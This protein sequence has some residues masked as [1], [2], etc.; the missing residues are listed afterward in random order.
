[1]TS[2]T[3]VTV[4]TPPSSHTA[5]PGRRARRRLQR[6]LAADER[7]QAL[8]LLAAGRAAGEMSAQPRDRRVGVCAGELQLD[9]AVELLEA[10]VAADLRLGRPE[11]PPERLLQLRSLRHVPSSSV[12]RESPSSSK[13]PLSFRRASCRV[14]YSAPRVVLRRSASTSIGTPFRASA[15][16][17]RRWCGVR[18]SSIARCNVS[19]SSAR[20][21]ASPGPP[22]PLAKR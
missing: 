10:L 11:Q 22:S 3:S 19:S 12:S 6:L 18:T 13:C 8:V 4:A 15:T 14:L 1:M 7:A 20:S 16:R 21:T 17:T 2:T 9:V 5:A